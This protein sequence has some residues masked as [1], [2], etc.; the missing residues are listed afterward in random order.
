MDSLTKSDHYSLFILPSVLR[1]CHVP[2]FRL[3]VHLHE[4]PVSIILDKGIVFS[5][6][7]WQIFQE[8]LGTRVDL[9]IAFYPHTDGKLEKI[10]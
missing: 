3:I 4:V 6:S 9:T 8:E 1:G 2:T 10:I 7:F 5:S